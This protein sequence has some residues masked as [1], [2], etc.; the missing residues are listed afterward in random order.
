MGLLHELIMYCKDFLQKGTVRYDSDPV[1]LFR[2]RIR[3][4]QKSSVYESLNTAR[5]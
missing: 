5:R 1:Q 3:P 4:D 2:I